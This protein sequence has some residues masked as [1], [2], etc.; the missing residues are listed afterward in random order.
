MQEIE[1]PSTV[2]TTLHVQLHLTDIYGERPLEKN[3]IHAL[4]LNHT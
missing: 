4:F 3:T 1:L 2:I